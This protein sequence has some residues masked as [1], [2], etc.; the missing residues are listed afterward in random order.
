MKTK[1][2]LLG[3]CALLVVAGVAGW[4]MAWRLQHQLVTLNV[5]NAPL[6]LVRQQLQRQTWTRIRAEQALDSVGVTL[7]VSDK[8]LSKVLARIA[9]QAR[10][11]WSSVYAVYTSAH[12]L[13]AL[14]SALRGA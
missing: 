4:R 11:H 9:E 13:Q 10:A 5:R 3:I 7:R 8:P 12:A 1:Y 6:P 14:D 2:L